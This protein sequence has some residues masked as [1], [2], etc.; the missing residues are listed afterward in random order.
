MTSTYQTKPLSGSLFLETT[1]ADP[2]H[3]DWKGSLKID[4]AHD[5]WANGFIKK[6]DG[7]EFISLS[8]QLKGT[9]YSPTD[10]K[11]RNSGLLSQNP[12]KIETK[13]PDLKGRVNVDGTDYWLSAWQN[14]SATGKT[15][16]K[17]ALSKMEQSAAPAAEK[18]WAQPQP[19][20][21]NTGLDIGVPPNFDD[22]PPF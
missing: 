18:A 22:N 13:H 6:K 7:K 12:K 8:V 10:D 15:Y 1:K 17:L 5:Y 2:K 21:D 9:K 14:K 20:A 3:A 4:D 19:D 16:L 11:S